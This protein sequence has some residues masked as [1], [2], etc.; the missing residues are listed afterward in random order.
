MCEYWISDF[1]DE[2]TSFPNGRHDDQVDALSQLLIWVDLQQRYD[3]VSIAAPL[4][5]VE[6]EGWSDGWHAPT[7]HYDDD[8]WA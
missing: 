3:Q 2:A 1:L 6:G 5:F 4:I 7:V 8:P